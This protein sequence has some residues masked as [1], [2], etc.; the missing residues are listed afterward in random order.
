[1][2]KF[3]FNHGVVILVIGGM[4]ILVTLEICLLAAG[5]SEH[6]AAKV[7]GALAVIWAPAFFIWGGVTGESDDDF[8]N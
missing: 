8:S 3:D 4:V 6:E 7:W 5:Y 2:S 1:M